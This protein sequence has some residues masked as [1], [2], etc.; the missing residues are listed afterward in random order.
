MS[1][2]L[3]QSLNEGIL[4]LTINRPDKLNAL[5]AAL[6]L[7]LNQALKEA[8]ANQAVRVIIITGSGSKAF[9]AGADISEFANYSVEEGKKLSADG[10]KLLFNYIENLNKPVIAAVNGFALGGGFELALSCHVRVGSKSAKVGFPEVNLG[11]IPGYGG[12]QRLSMLCGKGKAFELILTAD[13][14]GAE[15]A[16]GLGLF[17]HVV[18][19]SELLDFC[20]AMAKRMI[21]KSP[22]AIQRAIRAIN[23]QHPSPSDAYSTEIDQFGLCFG[24]PDFIEGTTAFLEKRKPDFSH[25][26]VH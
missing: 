15:Q 1:E 2:S 12:T 7:Q 9:V 20:K 26:L 11:V 24:T 22:N 10:H 13:M 17:N 8:S 4:T 16:L 5:N 18:E 14:L 19:E 6:I 21:S 25:G 3:L 23:A